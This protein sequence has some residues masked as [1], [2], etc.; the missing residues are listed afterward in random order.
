MLLIEF[1]RDEKNMEIRLFFFYCATVWYGK[2]IDTMSISL[3]TVHI[4]SF[5]LLRQF[6]CWVCSPYQHRVVANLTWPML[7]SPFLTLQGM[8]PPP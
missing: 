1:R 3:M 7:V 5:R 2:I 8:F 6:V 4:M